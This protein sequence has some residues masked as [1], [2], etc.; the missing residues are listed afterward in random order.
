[1]F[2]PA[3][4]LKLIERLRT[5]RTNTEENNATVENEGSPDSDAINDLNAIFSENL[6][7]DEDRGD[8]ASSSDGDED[9]CAGEMYAIC[10]TVDE[11][12]LGLYA[13]N[14]ERCKLPDDNLLALNHDYDW[15]LDGDLQYDHGL[16]PKSRRRKRFGELALDVPLE[17]M[18]LEDPSLVTASCSPDSALDETLDSGEGIIEFADFAEFDCDASAIKANGDGEAE[19]NVAELSLDEDWGGFA[20]AKDDNKQSEVQFDDKVDEIQV[21]NTPE[22]DS[23]IG[24]VVDTSSD[25]VRCS[26]STS[27]EAS[28][29]YKPTDEIHQLVTDLDAELDITIDECLN[30]SMDAPA[31]EEDCTNDNSLESQGR[32]QLSTHGNLRCNTY[33]SEH[34]KTSNGIQSQKAHQ[35]PLLMSSMLMESLPMPIPDMDTDILASFTYRVQ[36]GFRDVARLRSEEIDPNIEMLDDHILEKKLVDILRSGYFEGAGGDDDNFDSIVLDEVL[37]VPWPFYQLV[38]NEPVVE[39]EYNVLDP[40]EVDSSNELNFDSYIFNR[41]SQLDASKGEVMNSILARVSL[42]KKSIDSGN[43]RILAAELDLAAALM[44]A[45]SSRESVQ[46]MLSGYCIDDELF[47]SDQRNAIAGGL[48]VLDIADTRDR[49]EYLGA[50]VER[51]SDICAQEILFWNEIPNLKSHSSLPLRPE[52]YCDLIELARKLYNLTLDEEVLNHVT[53]LHSLRD[54]IQ[55][56][57]A[58]LLECMEDSIAKLIQQM[59][60]ANDAC[61]DVYL[62]QY[63]SLVSSWI[64]CCRLRDNDNDSRT[65]P[66]STVADGWSSCLL[67]AFCFEVSKAYIHSMI[68]TIES[69]VAAD[70]IRDEVERLKCSL[71]N[72]SDIDILMAR[73]LENRQLQSPAFSHQALRSAEILSVFCLLCEHHSGIVDRLE[74]VKAESPESNA[75]GDSGNVSSISADELS[76]AAASSSSSSEGTDDGQPDASLPHTFEFQNKTTDFKSSTHRCMLKSMNRSI[77]HPLFTFCESKLTQSIEY[78]ISCTSTKLLLDDLCMMNDLLHQFSDFAVIFLGDE[79]DE[80]SDTCENIEISLA[81]LCRAHLRSV[82]VEAM[83]T[84]GTLLRHETWQI[85]SLDFTMAPADN[86]EKKSD[87]GGNIH[88]EQNAVLISLHHVRDIKYIFNSLFTMH[89]LSNLLFIRPSLNF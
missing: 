25:Q 78:C 22:D 7:S 18:E 20:S 60:N 35:H 79:H 77:R 46:R 43:E 38:L 27:H 83:K 21:K 30:T 68:D 62:Q 47:K 9:S 10:Q 45:N 76:S 74:S 37:N 36:K 1:M 19:T 39:N 87:G 42:K 82:H 58:V 54:R 13:L 32:L 70:F 71:T 24:C 55:R 40:E 88:Q 33:N 49:V 52:Q 41:L 66:M 59:L 89:L 86:D 34:L 72:D 53:C 50:T 61:N 14:D 64:S 8:V 84:T 44:Y 28:Y 48:D 29:E 65:C 16:T 75:E 11:S 6:L 3:S 23:F 85:S 56:L 51:I 69:D 67:K 4:N 2:S 15:L 81:E 57:P 17:M 63:E 73:L 5:L 12:L 26:Q 31:E 80:D